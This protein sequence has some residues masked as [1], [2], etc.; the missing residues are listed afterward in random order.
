MHDHATKSLWST[1]TGTPVVGP[2]VG[3]GIELKPLHVVTTTWKEWQRRHPETLVLSRDT[4]HRRDY[5][6]GVA[7]RDYFATDRLMFNVPRLD[8]RLPNKAEV[9]AL[10]LPQVRGEALAV[11]AD[12]LASRPVYSDR[13]GDVAFVVLTDASGANRVYESKDIV[14]VSWDKVSA[15]RDS[16]GVVWKMDEAALTAP[17]RQTLGRLP[18]H[19]ACWF[20]WS[21]AY[22]TTRL[23]K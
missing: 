22:P 15:V 6:E 11:A 13:I 9:L 21:A 12:F 7:Y 3:R 17:S 10:R 18:A 19:R 23:V 5:G 16:R 14:F 20:G 4:G 1:L 2:L 8:K